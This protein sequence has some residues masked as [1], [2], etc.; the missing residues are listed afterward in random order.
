MYLDHTHS[1]NAVL[2]PHHPVQSL[3]SEQAPKDWAKGHHPTW[4][5]PQRD[6]LVWVA[7]KTCGRVLVGLQLSVDVVL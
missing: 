4:Q 7:V 5:G 2:T 1:H 6:P 3:E